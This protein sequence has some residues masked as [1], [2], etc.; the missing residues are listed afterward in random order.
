MLSRLASNLLL[1]LFA[2][3]A[4]G[5]LFKYTAV[6]NIG[7]V[8][9]FRGGFEGVKRIIK[10]APPASELSE[11]EKNKLKETLSKQ[12]SILPLY[13]QSTYFPFIPGAGWTY[14]AAREKDSNLIKVGVPSSENGTVFLDGRL[15]GREDWTNRTMAVCRDNR[16]YLT[17]F[18]FLLVWGRER[19]VTTPCSNGEYNFSLPRDS[20]LKEGNTWLEK[21]CLMDELLAEDGQEEKI[22]IKRELE[23]KGK[24]LGTEKIVVPAGEFEAQK[25][26]LDLRERQEVAGGAKTVESAFD[27]WVVQGVGIVKSVFQ[28]HLANEPAVVQELIGFQ[29]PTEKIYKSNRR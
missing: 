8:E 10:E 2:L 1:F 11:G 24:V 7:F 12:N 21:G 18:N 19:T 29:I 6:L 3:V 23:I 22:E 20:Y 17:D 15:A 9:S 14:Q 25:I 27:I 5:L 13:C 16:I 4:V 26:K 28:K